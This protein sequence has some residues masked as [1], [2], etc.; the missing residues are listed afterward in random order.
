MENDA[1]QCDWDVVVVGAG[2]SGLMAARSLTKAGLQ[3][4]VIDKG[5]G[6]GGR[7][8]YRRI[9]EA[10]FDHGAQYL[11]AR[12]DGFQQHVSAWK[13]KGAAAVWSEGF[14]D[15]PGDHPRWRGA[16]HMKAIPSLLANGL[17][18]VT[19]AKMTQMQH[20]GDRW[21]IM[22]ENGFRYR[23]SALIMTPPVPQS[24][25][26][27]GSLFDEF[28]QRLQAVIQRLT[29]HRCFAVM[30][31]LDGP[32]GWENPG[33]KTFADGALAWMADNQLKGI[34]PVPCVTIHASHAFSLARWEED[35]QETA[36][37]MI[38]LASPW[39]AAQVL[40]FQIHGWRY[41]KPTVTHEEPFV[42]LKD[43][44]YLAF[45]G[46]AF[47]A[48]HRGNVEGAATSGCAVAESVIEFFSRK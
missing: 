40:D 41:S 44:P 46:D 12:G 25:D 33:V 35:R 21:E 45:A 26:L 15:L 19:N 18:V 7:M 9:G 11:S 2:M 39:I 5:R 31:V 1:G 6:V 8:A 47:G 34:S 42:V 36:R 37:M 43:Q 3:V 17:H 27:L 16:P 23:C 48:S 38:E 22:L 10:I 13:E 24:I 28:P 14:P 29:Y 30:A 20:D 32:S 4:L